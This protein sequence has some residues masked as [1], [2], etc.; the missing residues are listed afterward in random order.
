MQRPDVDIFI[1]NR[2]GLS[3]QKV[4]ALSNEKLYTAPSELRSGV[5]RLKHVKTEIETRLNG[6][7]SVISSV[8]VEKDNVAAEKNDT[9]NVEPPVI[10]K[11]CTSD[12]YSLG[13][14]PTPSTKKIDQNES[15]PALVLSS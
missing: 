5:T 10:T 15:Y 11:L 7:K 13:T 3:V 8:G 2:F 9:S 4:N 14:P 12:Y 1:A 6:K